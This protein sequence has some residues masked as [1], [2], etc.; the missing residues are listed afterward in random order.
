[1]RALAAEGVR[2]AFTYVRG[3]EPAQALVA[4]LT[5]AGGQVLALQADTAQPGRHPERGRRL[6]GLG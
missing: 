2:V 5:Q 3:V 6:V 4:D 1:M